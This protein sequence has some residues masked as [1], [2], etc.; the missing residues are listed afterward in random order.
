MK[1]KLGFTLVE[2]T[3]FLALSSSIMLGIILA[4]NASVARQRYSDSIND[5]SDFL[6]GLYS[7]VLNVENI[8]KAIGEGGSSGDAI[9]GKF[10]TFQE[11]NSDGTTA[12]SIIVR[13][14][15]GKA[16]S[17]ATEFTSDTSTPI[18]LLVSSEVDAYVSDTV[19]E[20]NVPWEAILEQPNAGYN[21]PSTPGSPV[22]CTLDSTKCFAGTILIFRSPLSGKINTYVSSSNNDHYLAAN[23]KEEFHTYL[24]TKMTTRDLDFCIDSED[25]TYSNRRNVRLLRNGANSTAVYMVEMDDDSLSR[26]L[27]K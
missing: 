7:A 27:Q 21:L 15:Y 22:D 2:V 13:D 3:L 10:V 9:Y 26:C 20:Y 8:D 14:L 16:V 18:N 24:T 11:T 1:I 4:T 12:T 19:S 6:R 23:T 25:N 17:S 5:F